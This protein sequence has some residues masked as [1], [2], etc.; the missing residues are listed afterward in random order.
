METQVDQPT[1]N[2]KVKNW[3]T[4]V[5]ITQL[6]SVAV[7]AAAAGLMFWK[8]TDTRISLLEMRMVAKEQ[9]DAVINSKLDKLQDGI[10]DVKVSLQN[11]QDR[12][13]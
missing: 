1:N 13:N 8:T 6:I 9:T 10:N 2:I 4:G 7:A 3:N 5:T 11:K 12:K